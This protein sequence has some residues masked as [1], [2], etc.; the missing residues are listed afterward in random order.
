[1]GQGLSA[2]GASM[3]VPLMASLI[4]GLQSPLIPATI[5]SI[6]VSNEI[7]VGVFFS[8][9]GAVR[10]VCQIPF[11]RLSDRFSVRNSMLEIGF[12][13]SG[14]TVLGYGFV[15]TVEGLLSL[16]VP[17]GVALAA[18]TPA[19]MAMVD[20]LTTP[21]NRGG[22]MGAIST[23][24]TLGW[25][26]GPVL[27]GALADQFG[28]RMA[29]ACGAL[30]IGSSVLLIRVVVPT[31]SP[32]W[33]CR[34]SLADG[35]G[36][37]PRFTSSR[38]AR[39]LVGV[40]IA[41]CVLMMGISTIVSLEKVIIDRL[42]NSKTGF[43]IVF[44]IPTFT[45]LLVQFPIGRWTD[46]YSRPP[47]ILSGLLASVPLVAVTGFVHTFGAFVVV[48][49][50]QGATVAAV[51]TPGYALAADVADEAH[52]GEQLAFVTTASSVGFALGP[53]V[54]GVLAPA[55]FV[56]P[57]LAIAAASLAS[58]VVVWYLIEDGSIPSLRSYAALF[59]R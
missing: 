49:G 27:G 58:V 3:V 23:L 25:G 24:R 45:R 15:G 44:A 40:A 1:M 52:S 54:S 59:R 46:Q 48:R 42:G 41:V 10:S 12:A 43:G 26:L 29:F 8:T 50:L 7:L 9:L 34:E 21:E 36:L 51:I 38:Q 19:L 14:A 55:G 16:R 5:V 56:A 22:G 18:A 13:V 39:T 47:M 31:V 6:A 33:N 32:D 53:L 28:L 30:L 17:Q 11:G 4:T 57:F 2:A 37:R 35:G 20:S